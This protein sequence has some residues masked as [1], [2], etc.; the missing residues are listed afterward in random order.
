[1]TSL[2]VATA[3]DLPALRDLLG[4][5]HLPYQD[6]TVAHLA[7]F[8]IAADEYSIHGVVGLERYGDN[9]L[10]RSLAVR[11]GNQF[12]GLGTQLAAAAEEHARGAGV[13][14]LYLL[15]TTAAGFFERRGYD[16]IARSEAPATLQKTTE[17]SSL[18][19]SQAIC[20]RRNLH[21]QP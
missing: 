7:D 3:R 11:P 5:A 1:M 20:L 19:P 17:F 6:L 10:L 12:A 15:T 8:L 2:R 21:H 13:A 9:A 16:V 4:S 18:C 14:T